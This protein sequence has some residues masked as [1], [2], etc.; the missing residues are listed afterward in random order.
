MRTQWK[1]FLQLLRNFIFPFP[2]FG[3]AR[4]VCIREDTALPLNS[5]ATG[6]F[7]FMDHLWSF[8]TITKW[9]D[10]MLHAFYSVT[11]M[12]SSWIDERWLKK[13][14]KSTACQKLFFLLQIQVE[15]QRASAKSIYKKHEQHQDNA[16]FDLFGK[17]ISWYISKWLVLIRLSFSSCTFHCLSATQCSCF[18][19]PKDC[20]KIWCRRSLATE[21]FLHLI[22]QS[23]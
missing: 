13:E 5:G 9:E 14:G 11:V 20:S 21:V 7:A 18:W 16:E 8:I 6:K 15:M 3:W 17:N 23:I 22:I 2:M 4:K 12:A 19:G 1:A 10:S